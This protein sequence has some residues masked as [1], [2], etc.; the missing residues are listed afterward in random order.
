MAGS[1]STSCA[2]WP[3]P[4]RRASRPGLVAD[5]GKLLAPGCRRL[6]LTA[7]LLALALVC[8]LVTS[9]CSRDHPVAHPGTAPTSSGAGGAASPYAGRTNAR[10]TGR[11]DLLIAREQALYLRSLRTGKETK[12]FSLQGGKFVSY[13]AWSPDGSRLAYIV[14]TPYR[15]Q[16]DWGDDLYVADAAGGNRHVVYVH[17]ASRVQLESPSWTPDGRSV[18][19]SY[20]RIVFN[21]EGQFDSQ[22]YEVRQGNI[23]AG[24]VTTLLNDAGESDLCADGMTIA[25]A[26]FDRGTDTW[27]MLEVAKVD[28]SQRRVLA[29]DLL[30]ASP[31]AR[32]LHD[33]LCGRRTRARRTAGKHAVYAGP[34]RRSAQPG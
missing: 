30:R 1:C 8:L 21:V 34:H 15:S 2:A 26:G 16:G 18:V 13:P 11:D 28:G 9:G 14:S 25:F 19:F 6:P 23:E 17:D 33:P 22:V 31:L 20:L 29:V 12:L 32:L 7:G 27:D 3:N 4:R 24:G 5:P 10:Q